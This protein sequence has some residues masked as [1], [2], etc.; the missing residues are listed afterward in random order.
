MLHQY[1]GRMSGHVQ[2]A[3]VG[4]TLE[5]LASDCDTIAFRHYHV[6]DD[7]VHTTSC[8]AQ[9]IESFRTVLGLE[10]AVSLLAQDAVGD[11]S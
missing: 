3:L 1:L 2:N 5:N 7:K 6:H 8:L 10:D 11:P 4:P 9:R